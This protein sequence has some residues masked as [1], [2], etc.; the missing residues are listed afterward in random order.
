MSHFW[1]VHK[2]NV[3]F[4]MVSGLFALSAFVGLWSGVLSLAPVSFGAAAGF[5]SA[6]LIGDHQTPLPLLI[7]AG[8][9]IGAALAW[10]VS[11]V[12]LRLT[13]HYLALATIALVLITRVFALNL[14]KYTGGANGIGVPRTITFPELVLVLVLTGAVFARLRK[15]GFGLAADAVREQPD[16]AAGVGIDV[17]KLRRRAFVLSGAVGGLAGVLQANLLQYLTPDSYYTDLAFVMLAAVVLGGAYHWLGAIVGAAVFAAL[18]ELL[19]SHLG[20]A[21]SVANGLLLVLIMVFVPR[22]IIDPQRFRRRKR[23]GVVVPAAAAA[24]ASDPADG[25]A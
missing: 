11:F 15:S 7:L 24:V 20:E 6:R 1:A 14:T 2:T 3:E 4:A 22:G 16:V 10:A 21:R 8:V 23:S 13:S 5:T 17:Q 19:R 9:L 18:P 12:L 25:G